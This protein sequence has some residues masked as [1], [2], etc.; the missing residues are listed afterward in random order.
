MKL[1]IKGQE[2]SVY[3][4]DVLIV[5]I[6]L[7]KAALMGIFS[8]DYQNELFIPF[9]SYFVENGG[10]PYQY[11]YDIGRLNAF[12]YPPMMLF[13]ES[14]SV[15]VI[16]ILGISSVFMTNFLFK[17]P[18]LIFDLVGLYFLCRMFP[19]KRKYAVVFYFASPITLYAVYMHGQLD[20]I[21]TVLLLCSMFYLSSK[22]R[23]R[24]IVGGVFL[25]CALL[26]KLHILA[27]L[28][29]IFMYGVSQ[30]IG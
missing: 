14:V 1:M 21:P 11:F 27:V 16:R 26:T 4:S 28:P 17:C 8:S 6:F 13:I 15:V 9:V 18:S 22:Y 29:I 5:C 30:K 25:I 3:K 23:S 2:K 19:D 12:P 10:N 7:L 24:Y 20:M